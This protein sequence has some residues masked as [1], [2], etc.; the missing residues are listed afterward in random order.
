MTTYEQTQ[1]RQAIRVLAGAAFA[2]TLF[3]LAPLRVSYGESR[4]CQ[5]QR[6]TDPAPI[7]NADYIGT[8][9]T[10]SDTGLYLLPSGRIYGYAQEEDARIYRTQHAARICP[11]YPNGK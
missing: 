3:L 11:A 10:E 8:L 4:Y 7:L 5:S 6:R 9:H 2:S 1:R